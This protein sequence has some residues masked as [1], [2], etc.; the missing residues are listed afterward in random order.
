MIMFSKKVYNRLRYKYPKGACQTHAMISESLHLIRPQWHGPAALSQH[1]THQNYNSID[2][3]EQK[4]SLLL[5]WMDFEL[6]R[7]ILYFETFSN[8]TFS[9]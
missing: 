5:P 9:Y 6:V 8:N 4:V 3:I 2:K 1:K 7:L